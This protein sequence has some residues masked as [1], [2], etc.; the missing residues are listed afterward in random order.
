MMFVS[1]SLAL[2]ILGFAYQRP[3]EFLLLM[4]LLAAKHSLWGSGR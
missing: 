3:E 4:M 1:Y 2:V